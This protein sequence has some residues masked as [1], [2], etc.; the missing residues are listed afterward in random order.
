MDA[1]QCRLCGK[2]HYG[3]CQ[4]FESGAKGEVARD[5]PPARPKK[6]SST[7]R[8]RSDFYTN[9]PMVGSVDRNDLSD[10]ELIRELLARV[11]SLEARLEVLDKRREY[12]KKLMRERRAK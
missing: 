12:Q 10:R 2:K 9:P 1:P 5:I 3:Q 11:E 6:K 8:V 7:V 4:E